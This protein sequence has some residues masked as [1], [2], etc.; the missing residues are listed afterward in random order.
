MSC[1]SKNKKAVISTEALSGVN[2][3]FS[4]GNCY[5]IRVFNLGQATVVSA[6]GVSELKREK[7]HFIFTNFKL[8]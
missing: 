5:L 7:M 6:Q 1:Q 8:K 3:A 4:L 2:L